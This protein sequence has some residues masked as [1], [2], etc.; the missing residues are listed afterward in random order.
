M[1]A[2]QWDRER[3]NNYPNVFAVELKD[4]AEF[5]NSAVLQYCASVNSPERR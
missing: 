3:I 1:I 2:D 4:K 5:K